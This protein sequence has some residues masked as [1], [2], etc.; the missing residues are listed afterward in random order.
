MDSKKLENEDEDAH[1]YRNHFAD[2]DNNDPDKI[3]CFLNHFE[4][5]INF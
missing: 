4:I 5:K 1:N 2:H 3:V